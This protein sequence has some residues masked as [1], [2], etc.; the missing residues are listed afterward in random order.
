LG[1]RVTLSGARTPIN[2]LLQLPSGDFQIES[3]DLVG[4]LAA[5][6]ELEKIAGL[7]ALRELYLPGRHVML[8]SHGICCKTPIGDLVGL[9]G[10][11]ELL[12]TVSGA[13]LRGCDYHSVCAVVFAVLA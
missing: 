13:T 11:S 4:T 9:D 2:D 12:G 7:T 8:E 5:P 10:E 1:G 6:K 3:L